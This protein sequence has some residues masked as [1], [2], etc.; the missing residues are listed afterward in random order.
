MGCRDDVETDILRHH[1][2]TGV[3]L[4]RR[5]GLSKDL[6]SL[7]NL[8]KPT[9]GNLLEGV[10]PSDHLLFFLVTPTLLP[11]KHKW[12]LRMIL[13]SRTLKTTILELIYVVG[14]CRHSSAPGRH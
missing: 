14:G 2:F 13:L 5:E 10:T 8:S 7:P 3:L 6:T 11:P 9:L 1:P 4:L 12:L